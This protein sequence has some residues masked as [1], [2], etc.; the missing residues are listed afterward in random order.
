MAAGYATPE[1]AEKIAAYVVT[2]SGKT[3]THPE[4]VKEGNL[5]FN[6]NCGVCHGNDGKGL[7]GAYPDLTL[8]MLKGAKIRKETVKRKIEALRNKLEQQNMP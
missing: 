1:D 2:L 4:Y 7:N 6:G 5:Y 8:P 3:P